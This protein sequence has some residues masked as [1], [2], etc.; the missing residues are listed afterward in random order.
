MHAGDGK[1]T[2]IDWINEITLRLRARS[3]RVNQRSTVRLSQDNARTGYHASDA[4]GRVHPSIAWTLSH[5]R[6]VSNADS[7]FLFWAPNKYTCEGLYG[8]GLVPLSRAYYYLSI[9]C[10]LF[11]IRGEESS[12]ILGTKQLFR[13][14]NGKKR[15]ITFCGQKLF[16]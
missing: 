5:P 7:T 6:G 9:S 13:S 10:T 15:K 3:A 1:L 14:K 2:F 8:A 16:N 11:F 4:R 12:K